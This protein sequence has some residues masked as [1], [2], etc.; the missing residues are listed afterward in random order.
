[1]HKKWIIAPLAIGL[2]IGL[3][4]LQSTTPTPAPTLAVATPSAPNLSQQ[5]PEGNTASA[6]DAE[7]AAWLQ[8]PKVIDYLKKQSDKVAL[9]E[10]FNNPDNDPDQAQ[11]MW[12]YIAT[13]ESEGAIM[14]FEAMHLKM[15][16]LEKNTSDRD[17]FDA[18]A[19]DLV[20]EYRARA[21][22]SAEQYNPENTPEFKRYK[23]AERVIIEEVNGMTQFPGGLDRQAYLRQRLLVARQQAYG[24]PAAGEEE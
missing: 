3:W 8:H 24:A 20:N 16:W 5:T 6:Q 19:T 23:I 2:G 9:R 21:A 22:A 15:A 17:A 10:Y 11:A 18:A 13:L 1:M 14:A 12:K 7:A 4:T